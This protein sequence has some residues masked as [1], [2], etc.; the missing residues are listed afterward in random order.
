MATY[1]QGYDDYIPQI[2]T[3]E[4]DL[5]TFTK[6]INER[7]GKYDEAR[8]QLSD[9]YNSMLNSPML[10]DEDNA[11]RDE[12]FKIIESDI[13]KLSGMDLSLRQNQTAA[14]N[15]FTQ[16]LNNKNIAHDM[17]YTKKAYQALEDGELIKVSD[18]K[19][20]WE[21]MSQLIQMDMLDYKNAD[22]ETALKMSAPKF[23][24]RVNI[25]DEIIP[26]LDKLDLNIVNES[27]TQPVLDKNGMP[28]VDKNGVPMTQEGRWVVR[29][30]NGQLAFPYM[31]S[32]LQGMFA[33]RGDALAYYKELSR[34]NR[35]LYA[36]EHANEYGGD[37]NQASDAYV[38]LNL[39]AMRQQMQ[40]NIDMIRSVYNNANDKAQM[41]QKRLEDGGLEPWEEKSLQKAIEEYNNDI[42]SINNSKEY[43]E[44]S[45][46]EFDNL[47]G[48]VSGESFDTMYGRMLLNGDI[49][50]AAE[51]AAMK[52]AEVSYKVN[53]YMQDMINHQYRVA[54]E[55]NRFKHQ[56]ALEKEKHG[57]RM[58]EK[59]FENQLKN[60]GLGMTYAGSTPCKVDPQTGNVS[61]IEVKAGTDEAALLTHNALKKTLGTTLKE[62]GLVDNEVYVINKSLEK[63]KEKASGSYDAMSEYVD[64]YGRYMYSIGNG[65]AYEDLFKHH[66]GNIKDIY[67]EIKNQT[68]NISASTVD[69]YDIDSMYEK[70]SLSETIRDLRDV[71]DSQ[72]AITAM[73]TS[74]EKSQEEYIKGIISAASSMSDEEKKD[75]KALLNLNQNQSFNDFKGHFASFDEFVKKGNY[76]DLKDAAKKYDASG[77]DTKSIQFKLMKELSKQPIDTYLSMYTGIHG[78]GSYYCNAEAVT[79]T[80]ATNNAWNR[81]IN[82]LLTKAVAEDGTNAFFVNGKF[83]KNVPTQSDA[84]AR[85]VANNIHNTMSVLSKDGN[86]SC[87]AVISSIACSDDRYAAVTFSVPAKY[88][89]GLSTDQ[90]E[91]LNEITVIVDK[92]KFKDIEMI[93]AMD[94]TPVRANLVMS[95]QY[96]INPMPYPNS[97]LNNY[98]ISLKMTQ[99]G[100]FIDGKINLYTETAEGKKVSTY[101]M[102]QIPQFA[103]YWPYDKADEIVKSLEQVLQNNE[104]LISNMRK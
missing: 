77:K 13:K 37:V 90:K 23:T 40:E 84:T 9:L 70:V 80:N 53:P 103:G 97:T 11:T 69:P 28:V 63:L 10:R 65:E 3:Y 58:L 27:V 68:L 7:Q 74:F 34:Y 15:V 38:K 59:A 19:A 76:K 96:Q 1:L 102:G 54:E 6:I 2:Q 101:N 83:G 22:K 51:F 95:G 78:F 5:N 79:Y 100:L 82:E 30:K 45:A 104:Y 66:H 89:N 46:R 36:N 52:N 91:G 39:K 8:K 57:Y 42:E 73:K 72:K 44:S 94:D 67:A 50:S 16:L 75:L 24:K 86:Q 14:S 99:N 48:N 4:P 56:Q 92:S 32:L 61:G 33:D 49:R 93:Q 62:R 81:D 41:D 43:A 64:I 17:V 18:P 71:S 55:N 87:T 21:G 26:M 20:Y 35:M 12:Y 25:M 60:H 88:M 29:Q 85:L 47:Q 98:P 31:Q